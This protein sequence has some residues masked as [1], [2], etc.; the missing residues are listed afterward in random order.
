[1]DHPGISDIL[2]KKSVNAT[3]LFKKGI[4]DQEIH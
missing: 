2:W 4:I 1:M 3:H